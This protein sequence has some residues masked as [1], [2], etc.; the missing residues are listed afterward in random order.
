MNRGLMRLPVVLLAVALVLCACGPEPVPTRTPGPTEAT[1]EASGTEFAAEVTLTLWHAWGE[2][3]VKSLAEVVSAFQTEN[4]DVRIETQYVPHDDLRSEYETAASAGGGPSVLIGAADWGPGLFDAGLVSDLRGMADARLLG[5]LNQAALGAVR[6]KGALVG[7]PQSVRG[8]VMFRNSDLVADVPVSFEEL[9]AVAQEATIGDVV[10]ASL[11]RGFFFSGAH[12]NAVGGL[13]MDEDGDP[14][15]NDDD[16]LVWLDL[17]DSFSQLGSAVNYA[18]SDATLFENGKV[19][20]II[21]STWN[22]ATLSEAI[23]A[24]KLSI[25]PWPT[26]MS[27][28]VLTENVYLN[29]NVEGRERLVAWAF[30]EFFLSPE[31]QAILADPTKAGHIPAVNGVEIADPLLAQAAEALSGGVTLPIIPEMGAYWGPM[32]FAL[33]SVFDEGADP[34]AALNQAYNSIV[35][36]IAEV[37]GEAV[38]QKTYTGTVVIWHSWE[39]Q[40]VVSLNEVIAAFQVGHADVQFEVLYVP[41]GDLLRRYQSATASSRGPSVLIGT[42][43]W[44]PELFDAGLVADVRGL[45]TIP[46]MG[47]I[48]EVALSAVKYKGAFVGLPESISGVVMFRNSAIIADAPATYEDL[49]AAAQ[50]ATQDDVSGAILE[51]GFAFSAG[52]LEGLG[53]QLMDGDGNPIFNDDRG[54]QWLNLLT[55]FTDVGPTVYNTDNDVDLFKAGQ[56][57]IIIATT[58]DTAG[59]AEAIGSD[60]L[61]IDP[62]PAFGEDGRLSGYVQAENV[63]LSANVEGDGQAAAWAFMAFFLSPEAHTILADPTKAGHIP[64]IIGVEV[65][66]PHIRQSMEALASGTAMPVNP[67]MDVYWGPL[68]TALQSVFDEGASPVEALQLAYDDI[69]AAVEEIRGGQ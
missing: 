4:P 57:G 37:R 5:A 63:Y 69:V 42:A 47:A 11:D 35:A 44:G 19:G 68:E 54:V 61:I 16:G 15:F 48:N 36:S 64:A 17:L 24:D 21:D 55:S 13:L 56:A 9:L 66:D 18:E 58:E 51:R 50:A 41:P 60:N 14:L 46:L 31:A 25:D 52:H 33:Q 30:M 45:T 67:E 49:A 32:E 27:G 1:R 65:G 38:P 40:E 34:A 53:G 7:L 2:D 59:L 3:E 22:A 26:S 62:W 12:L 6:Y 39:E 43:D 29:A 20:I 8:V 10:G 28:Y 23:G